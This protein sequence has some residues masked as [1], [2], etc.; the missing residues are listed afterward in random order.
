MPGELTRESLELMRDRLI[1]RGAA[2]G[3]M[4][5]IVELAIRA[6]DTEADARLGAKVREAI[7]DDAAFL[8]ALPEPYGAEDISDEDGDRLEDVGGRVFNAVRETLR[9]ESER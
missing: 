9:E 8:L 7:G 4:L 3:T 6:L 5:P 2:E 1:E